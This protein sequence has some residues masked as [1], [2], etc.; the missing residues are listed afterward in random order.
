M[1]FLSSVAQGNKQLQKYSVS[2]GKQT[3]YLY[4]RPHHDDE[5]AI[6]ANI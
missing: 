1:F 5:T 6:K 2:K 3:E 4:F